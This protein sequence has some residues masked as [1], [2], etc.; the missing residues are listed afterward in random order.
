MVGDEALRGAPEAHRVPALEL[1]LAR[2]QYRPR[3]NR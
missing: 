1:R 2:P 3:K